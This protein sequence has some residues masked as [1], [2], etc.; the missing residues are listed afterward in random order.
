MP[1]MLVLTASQATALRGPTMPGRALDP[2][3]IGGGV[4]VL[5]VA[6][7]SDDHGGSAMAALR[8]L[9]QQNVTLPAPPA[10]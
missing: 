3:D 4:Y 6:V 8:A 9:P 1:V 7:L 2:R 10:E 5:P